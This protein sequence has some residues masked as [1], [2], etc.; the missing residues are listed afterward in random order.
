MKEIEN[1]KNDLF[2]NKNL[3]YSF[4]NN[5][6]EIFYYS[7]EIVAQQRMEK[8]NEFKMDVRQINSLHK[9]AYLLGSKSCID[10]LRVDI[11]DLQNVIHDIIGKT[12]SIK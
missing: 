3:L 6:E 4:Q 5:L 1:F 9:M 10:S 2:R 7:N 8:K 11:D 12:G